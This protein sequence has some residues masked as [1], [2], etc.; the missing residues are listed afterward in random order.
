MNYKC[1][2]PVFFHVWNRIDVVKRVFGQIKKAKPAK[3]YL[4]SDGP[5]NSIDRKKIIKIRNYIN[6]NI[7]WKCNVIK[8]Y[9]KKNFGPKFAITTNLNT[10]FKKEEKLIVLDHDC[11]V[12]ISFFRYCDELLEF[13][14]KSN[15]V[16]M[17]SGNYVCKNLIKK[18]FSYYF[19]FHPIIF[20]WAGWKRSWNE[21]DIKMKKF[22]PIISFIWLLFFFKFNIVKALYFYNKFKLTKNNKINTWDY[23]LLFSIWMKNGL[24]IR[25]T[26]NISK[27]IGWGKQAL[28]GTGTD[29]LQDIKIGRLKF[30]L[31]HPKKIEVNY[32]ADQ[33]EYLRVRKLYFFP[34]LIFFIKNKIKKICFS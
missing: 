16:K 29:D 26:V 18:N 8:I 28:H 17:I 3:L 7:N 30:P 13:Y 32:K 9:N 6:N 20:G 34:S 12:D 31:K 24:L 21:Y 22:K 11:L 2:S 1:Q 15:R 10:V 25:P 23:Q 4:S 27:H 5:R 14:K 33:I 19:G